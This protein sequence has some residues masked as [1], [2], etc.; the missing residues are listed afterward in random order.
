MPQVSL[1]NYESKEVEN[2]PNDP[3]VYDIMISFTVP[4]ISNETKNN[5]IKL[6]KTN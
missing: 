3:V 2:G 4:T 6:K 5:S 1:I